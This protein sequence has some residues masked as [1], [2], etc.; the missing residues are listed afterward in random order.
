MGKMIL[1]TGGS[2]SGK[3]GYAQRLAESLAEKKLFIATCPVLDPEL[4][5]RVDRHRADRAG[6]C[7]DTIEEQTELASVLRD[8][9]NYPV[10][11]IDCLTLWINNRMYHAE[12]AGVTLTEE[13]IAAASLEVVAACRAT[14]ATVIL[15]TNE[16]GMGV[17]PDNAPARLFRDLSGRCNQ[18]IAAAAEEV[19][20]LVSGL[21]LI[22][23]KSLA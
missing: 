7:W 1:I 6:R 16:V 12:Q 14:A 22:L 15:V 8:R 20:L 9:P 3:S 10:I 2:R 13:A 19:F 4:R 5:A 11:L 21:P 17:I 23:K 18:I